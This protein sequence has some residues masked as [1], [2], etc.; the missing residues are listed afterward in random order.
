MVLGAQLATGA[1]VQTGA[2]AHTGVVA[3]PQL[4]PLENIPLNLENSFGLPYPQVSQA[5]P[6]PADIPQPVPPHA[7]P[8]DTT[9]G[10]EVTATG[11]GVS[12]AS[13]ADVINRKAAFT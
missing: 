5:L 8:E 6:Q 3:Q 11:A 2:G 4:D 1:G 10:A 12:P 13:N 7:D 9:A